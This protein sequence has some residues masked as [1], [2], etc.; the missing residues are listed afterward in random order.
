M[1]RE[2]KGGGL[3]LIRVLASGSSG[4]CTV[5]ENENGELLILDAGIDIKQIKQGINFR[6]GDIAGC[7]ITHK[8][9]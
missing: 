6:V 8:H 2:G 1:E 3:M 4:N 5:I 7:V 9:L